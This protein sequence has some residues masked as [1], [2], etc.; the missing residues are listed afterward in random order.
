MAEGAVEAMR[1]F[2]LAYAAHL[3][4][5]L[6]PSCQGHGTGRRLIQ[7]LCEHLTKKGIPGVMLNVANDNAGAKHFYE[8][9]GFIPLEAGEMETAYGKNLVS[10]PDLLH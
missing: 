4:I 6:L 5:D 3:H 1:P 10:D 8:K 9:C 2:S 7:R